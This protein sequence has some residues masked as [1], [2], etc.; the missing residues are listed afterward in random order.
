MQTPITCSERR[1]TATFL[2]LGELNVFTIYQKLSTNL[3][4]RSNSVA[5][6]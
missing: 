1:D 3:D 5:Q 2:E 6:Y 4:F